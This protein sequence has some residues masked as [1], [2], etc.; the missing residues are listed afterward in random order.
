MNSEKRKIKFTNIV[1]ITSVWRKWCQSV[2]YEG[3]FHRF[4]SIFRLFVGILPVLFSRR[5]S[6]RLQ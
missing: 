4:L 1:S 6:L 2:Y 5:S 3:C